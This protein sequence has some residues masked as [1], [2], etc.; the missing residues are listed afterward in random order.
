[1]SAT[2]FA[3]FVSV[4]FDNNQ[5]KAAEALGVDR[6]HVSR[7]CGGDRDITPALAAKVEQLSNGQFRKEALIWPDSEAA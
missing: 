3:E 2:L 5:A 4:C 7:L 1:M 6:S